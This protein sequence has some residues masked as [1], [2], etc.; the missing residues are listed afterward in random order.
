MD[1]KKKKYDEETDDLYDNEK[2]E[3][4]IEDDEIE[5]EE[6]GFM[7]GYNQKQK[8]DPKEPKEIV[9]DDE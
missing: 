7:E 1:D 5:P 4:A 9:Q 6:A 8:K 3:E 2:V